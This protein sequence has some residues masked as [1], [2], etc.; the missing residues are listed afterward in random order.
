MS[1]RPHVT[2]LVFLWLAPRIKRP[3]RQVPS[4]E[5]RAC[6]PHTRTRHFCNPQRH[7]GEHIHDALVLSVARKATPGLAGCGQSQS[8]SATVPAKNEDRQT[9]RPRRSIALLPCTCAVRTL[10]CPPSAHCTK[11]PDL[12]TLIERGREE[13]DSFPLLFAQQENRL[14]PSSCCPP[15]LPQF[16]RATTFLVLC[17]AS[18]YSVWAG[19]VRPSDLAR[20]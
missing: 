5:A 3:A 16:R 9:G 14:F 15:F 13:A 4:G 1:T 10:H 8:R 12:V 20:M 11:R 19:R 2:V 6:P 7:N 18:E 17:K